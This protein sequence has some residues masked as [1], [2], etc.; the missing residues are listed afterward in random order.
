MGKYCSKIESEPL[1]QKDSLPI[2]FDF[3]T[4][5]DR[6]QPID[7][8][9]PLFNTPRG[10][11]GRDRLQRRTS[12]GESTGNSS[13]LHTFQGSIISNA[14]TYCNS[15]STCEIVKVKSP[16]RSPEFSKCERRL[17]V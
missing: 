9:S 2:D 16:K 7:L 13:S 17:H 5:F 4:P 11:N 1:K 12:S 15:T 10:K 3:K 8:D 14:S 6:I